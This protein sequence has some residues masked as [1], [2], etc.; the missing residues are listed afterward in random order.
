MSVERSTQEMWV[1]AD[2]EDHK[3]EKR[4][5]TYVP[6]LYKIFDEILV[7]AAD[8]S[9][10]DASMSYVKVNI[11]RESGEISVENDGRGIPVQ[12]HKEHNVYVPD[13]IF[14]RLTLGGRA[15]GA[16]KPQ[17]RCA[18]SWRNRCGTLTES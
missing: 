13:L 2:G 18:E 16:Q 12:I 10:R 7:N 5:V 3:F 11:D 9:K 15:H 6:A 4:E 1:L 8:N 14:G 17:S